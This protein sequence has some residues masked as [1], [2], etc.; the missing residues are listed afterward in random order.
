MTQIN[1][2]PWRERK[3]EEQK[4]QFIMLVSATVSGAFLI[5]LLINYFILGRVHNQSIRNQRVQQEIAIYEHRLIEIDNLRILREQLISKMS[6]LQKIQSRRTYMVHLFDELS[7]V[8]PDGIYLTKIE[9]ARDLITASG[10]AK[11]HNHIAQIMTNIEC[12]DWIHHPVL[13][14]I[15]KIAQKKQ[16]VDNRF[17]ITFSLGLSS[18]VECMK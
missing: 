7:K 9:G 16:A 13:R 18:L 1:L 2:L 10:Y 8:I 5:V 4:K 12:N 17:R 11:S 6:L 15:K 14:E 3:R